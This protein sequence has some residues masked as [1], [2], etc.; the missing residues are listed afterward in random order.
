[1]ALHMAF[2]VIPEIAGVFALT[3]YLHRNS[4]V[5][6]VKNAID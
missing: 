1:M 4:V 3:S 2:R 5:L 6:Q